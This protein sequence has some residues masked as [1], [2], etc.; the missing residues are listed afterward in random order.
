MWHDLQITGLLL[1]T[2]TYRKGDVKPEL[3]R[4]G[5]GEGHRGSLP[6]VAFQPPASKLPE[7]QFQN[8]LSAL[9]SFSFPSLCFCGLFSP[10]GNPHVD[11]GGEAWSSMWKVDMVSSRKMSQPLKPHGSSGSQ[12]A[13]PGK[14]QMTHWVIGGQD[15]EIVG[16]REGSQRGWGSNPDSAPDWLLFTFPL[17]SQVKGQKWRLRFHGLMATVANIGMRNLCWAKVIKKIFFNMLHFQ[18]IQLMCLLFSI[19]NSSLSHE[20]YRSTNTASANAKEVAITLFLYYYF[21]PH[22]MTCRTQNLSSLT[23]DQTYS[24]ES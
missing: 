6:S 10:T 22:L 21:W 18:F 15:G 3:G 4:G 14:Q 7:K 1:L 17:S 9:F 12:P 16:Q 23:R 13:R 24:M 20:L 11:T 8:I 19:E 2:T 5:Q